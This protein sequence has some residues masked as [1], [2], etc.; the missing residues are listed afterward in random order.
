MKKDIAYTAVS[1]SHKKV[2][3]TMPIGIM[4]SRVWLCLI[5]F[6]EEG[7]SM[8]ARVCAVSP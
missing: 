7:E 5:E 4:G 3:A 2:Y 8:N 1:L 6:Q